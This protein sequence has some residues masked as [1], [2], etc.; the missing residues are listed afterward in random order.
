MRRA[1]LVGLGVWLAS[2]MAWAQADPPLRPGA[3]SGESELA[4]KPLPVPDLL[5]RPVTMTQAELT[6]AAE[7]GD[8]AAQF[9][10]GEGYL[11]GRYGDVDDGA[12]L[13]WY[14]RAAEQGHPQAQYIFGWLTARGRGVP[15]N[16]AEA[17][18]WYRRSA[19]Q[20]LRDAQFV[21][22]EAYATGFGMAAPDPQQAVQWYGLAAA[23]RHPR[24][25]YKMG[26][27]YR[28]H[29]QRDE[30]VACLEKAAQLGIVDAKRE[31]DELPPR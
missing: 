4:G 7:R 11:S 1:A 5:A 16:P 30:A 10:L 22:A 24:A 27:A 3:C 23:Q 13:R 6:A 21:L 20:Q 25:L 9:T 2:A 31:L 19:D 12:G 14:R 28:D 26:L 18:R 15:F 17:V 29:G 8:A